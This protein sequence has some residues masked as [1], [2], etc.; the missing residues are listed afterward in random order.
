MKEKIIIVAISVLAVAALS[1]GVLIALSPEEVEPIPVDVHTPNS[2]I[3]ALDIE[4]PDRKTERLLAI[5]TYQNKSEFSKDDFKDIINIAQ[6]GGME[7]L[8][9]DKSDDYLLIIPYEI[10]GKMEISGVKYDEYNEEYVS[11]SSTY[12][13]LCNKG[14]ELP[15]NYCL[16]VRYSRP[17]TPAYEIKLSQNNGNQTATYQIVNTEKNGSP[18][19]ILQ[20]IKDDIDKGS[21]SVGEVEI[22][23]DKGNER[24]SGSESLVAEE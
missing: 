17:A 12:Y 15:D 3:E 5:K 23:I 4:R 21:E 1:L 24:K 13:Y 22:V 8:E 14:K 16:L 19:K 20:R 11:D 6:S 9:L 2:L 18:V 10:N 7:Y